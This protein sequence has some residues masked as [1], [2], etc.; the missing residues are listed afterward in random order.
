MALSTGAIFVSGVAQAAPPPPLPTGKLTGVAMGASGATF[1]I[2]DKVSRTGDVVDVW[3]YRVFEP[4]FK[5]GE[6]TVVQGLANWKFDCAARSQ[7]DIYSAGFDASDKFIVDLPPFPAKPL[8]RE[9]AQE[10]VGKVVCDGVQMPAQ[11]TLVGYKAAAMMARGLI[12]S[13][14]KK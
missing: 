2:P 4:G 5:V 6:A 3:V 13:A 1:L 14:A 9:S 11:N 7:A 12:Q 10:F 8:E